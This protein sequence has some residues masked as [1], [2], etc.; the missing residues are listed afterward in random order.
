MAIPFNGKWQA[1][2]GS[3]HDNIWDAD[4]ATKRYNLELER[5]KLL[6]EQ[7]EKQKSQ[8][9]ADESYSYRDKI[10]RAYINADRRTDTQIK[11]DAIADK[12]MLIVFIIVGGIIAVN[13][14]T[15][16]HDLSASIFM[17]MVGAFAGGTAHTVLFYLIVNP[18]FRPGG[19]ISDEELKRRIINQEKQEQIENERLYEETSKK[20]QKR[21]NDIDDIINGLK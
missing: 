21:E 20:L 14:S 16:M 4:A 6:K 13:M 15:T 10:E 5:N 7:N 3:L 17:F 19:E 12:F 8:N 11:F 9:T 1:K 18:L 2:D